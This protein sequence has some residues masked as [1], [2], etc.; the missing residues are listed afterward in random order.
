VDLSLVQ[1]GFLLGHEPCGG[2]RSS[3]ELV[4]CSI[5]FWQDLIDS[6]MLPRVALSFTLCLNSCDTPLPNLD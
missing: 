2:I 3:L 4:I 1:E 6:L 5:R